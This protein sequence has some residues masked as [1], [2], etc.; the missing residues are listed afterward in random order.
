[1][2]NENVTVAGK[3]IGR[4]NWSTWERFYAGVT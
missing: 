1:M 3:R 4:E 2:I